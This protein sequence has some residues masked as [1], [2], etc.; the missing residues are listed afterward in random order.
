[1]G[2]QNPHGADPAFALY[3]LPERATGGRL[4]A[5]LGMTASQYL[6]TFDRANLLDPGVRWRA[7]DARIAAHRLPH[8]RRIL[9][10]RRVA[11]AHGVQFDCFEP[12]EIALGRSD[13]P[14][15]VLVLPHPSGLNR[16]WND[17]DNLRRARETVTEFLETQCSTA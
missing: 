14:A 16:M 4:A 15:I 11:E 9:L 10:G 3:P 12:Y 8:D 2:E 13:R 1:V 7:M 6:R 5:I 17:P